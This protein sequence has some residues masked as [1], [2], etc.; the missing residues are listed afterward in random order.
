MSATPTTTAQWARYLVLFA[1]EWFI[2]VLTQVGHVIALLAGA[3]DAL[4]TAAI[5]TRRISYISGQLRDA[6]RESWKED[7]R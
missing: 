5:G 7:H 4:V 2:G 6:V 1:M 3:A